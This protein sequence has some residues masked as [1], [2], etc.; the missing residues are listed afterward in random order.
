M[1]PF[2]GLGF[3]TVPRAIP[4]MVKLD[5]FQFATCHGETPDRPLVPIN[6]QL[7]IHELQVYGAAASVR[8]ECECKNLHTPRGGPD[9]R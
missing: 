1:S 3:F 5:G 7:R 9:V 8:G 6:P 4:V 2:V